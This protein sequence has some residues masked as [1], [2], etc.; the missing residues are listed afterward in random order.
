MIRVFVFLVLVGLLALG[1]VWLADRP[2]EV[3]VVW[4]GY[5]IETSV[6]VLIAAIALVIVVAMLIWSLVRAIVR[7]P[8]WVSTWLNQRRGIR[9]Y[10][11]ISNGLVS[12]GSGDRNAAVRYAAEAGRVAPG[13]PLTLLLKAQ[14]AQLEGR[15]EDAEMAFQSMASR[16]DTK[17]L[18]LRG[19]FIEAR[20][21]EDA[22]AARLYAEEAAQTAPALGWAGQA[23]LEFRCTSGDWSGALA[24]LERNNRNG[25]MRR[26]DYRRQRAVLLTAQAIAAEQEDRD[27]DSVVPLALEAVK[28][29]PDLIPAAELAGRRLG[30]ANDLRRASRIIETAW[31]ANPH[32]DLAD[33][34]AHLRVGDSARERLSRV[35]RLAD[36]APGHPESALAVARAA[37]DAQEFA[38]ARAALRPLLRQPTQRV[39]ILMAEIESRES[40]NEGRSRE[41]MARALRAARDPAWTADGMVS[42]RWLPVSPVD[43]RIDAFVWRVPLAELSDHR[44][45][46]DLTE[47]PASPPEPAPVIAVQ[48]H[49][50][51]IQEPQVQEPV[52]DTPPPQAPSEPSPALAAAV[53]EPVIVA[54]EPQPD[55]APALEPDAK[56]EP[57]APV[58]LAEIP[59]EPAAGPAV[60]EP[61]AAPGHKPE[62]GSGPDANPP[63]R[64]KPAKPAQRHVDTVIPLAR[65]PDDP[66]PEGA[67]IEPQPVPR[68]RGPYGL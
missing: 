2:G 45:V 15:R 1:V 26:A 14:V 29:A 41:W 35:Q 39:A 18:G 19:L 24:A 67:E 20:R 65:A 64:S 31:T 9:G 5:R 28:L 23:V 30:E 59:T 49:E 56:P 55:G 60:S 34:Y 54:P 7:S 17:L 33:T 66:G 4:Q 6:T 10:L 58:P 61:K 13:E 25:L 3:A 27:R 57:A 51:Q 62:P 52:R 48:I 37:L 63:R 36:R 68:H 8:G 22:H 16:E 11:A 53:A 47:E 12:V 21:R 42:D 46:I 32:P 43:G 40:G 44:E 38:V 50:P